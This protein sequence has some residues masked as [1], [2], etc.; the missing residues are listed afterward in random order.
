MAFGIFNQKGFSQGKDSIIN[1]NAEFAGQFYPASKAELN[2]TLKGLFDKAVSP[3]SDACIAIISPHAGYVYSAQVAASAFNQIQPDKKYQH[4]FV[5]ASSHHSGFDGAAIYYQG[6]YATPLGE[7]K[8]DTAL[9]KKLMKEHPVFKDNCKV[10]LGEHSLE[11]QLPFLQYV[12]KTDYQII[13]IILGTQSAETCKK[14]AKALQPYLTPD[15]LFI[16]STDFSHY[17]SYRD[18]QK[19]DKITAD[20]ILSCSPAVLLDKIKSNEKQNTGGLLTSLCGWTS[21]LTLLYMIENN[22]A[23]HA[24]EVQYSNSGDSPYGDSARVVGYHA[25]SF[26][27]D[28]SLL[29]PVPLSAKA[30]DELL[31]PDEKTTLLKLARTTLIEYIRNK[32]LSPLD[33]AD[34]TPALSVP[35]GAFVSLHKKGSLR[36]CIGNFT[37]G[38][39]LY[40]LIRQM[41]IAAATE[42]HR[43]SPL[44]PDE[45]DNIDIEISV[46]SSMKKITSIAEITL[47][48][49]G[50][51]LKKGNRSGT[52]LPQVATE[53]GWTKEEFLG[54]CAKDK[55]GLGWDGWKD[56][57]MYIYS[58]EVFSEK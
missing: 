50:I 4:I 29:K 57:E 26:S 58:A 47:G 36:G 11:V 23:I 38:E 17:P 48:K 14:I 13:P 52:F 51:Y 31:S 25:M 46:L 43:F 2:N 56:A 39:P 24:L 34:F 53:T 22:T 44:A 20:A 7:V 42:D 3:K 12:M 10:H 35:C 27:A 54:H 40:R 18:A 32:K 21:V 15:N 8:V 37:S 19:V 33:A 9:A 5:L 55:A 16:I 49:H 28:T 6:N 30:N 1:R 41:T 45:I